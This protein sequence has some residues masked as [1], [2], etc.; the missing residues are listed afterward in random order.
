MNRSSV[1]V[2]VRSV[3]FLLVLSP[4]LPLQKV[5]AQDGGV[6]TPSLK[7]LMATRASLLPMPSLVQTRF[8]TTPA[9][10]QTG[11]SGAPIW[12]K[13]RRTQVAVGVGVGAVVV[14][15][16]LKGG[17]SKLTGLSGAPPVAPTP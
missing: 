13:R 2:T 6:S 4:G 16:L 17:K 7:P 9:L 12:W 8:L 15:L 10:F 3:L 1:T 11:P 14:Y 5:Y